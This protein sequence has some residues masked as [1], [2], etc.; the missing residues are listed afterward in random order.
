MEEEDGYKRNERIALVV[1]LVMAS[2]AV[3]T[4][5]VTFIY[6][7]YITNKVSRR[8]NNRK[9]ESEHERKSSTFCHIQVATE[10]G[11]QEFTF[12]Q[13]HSATGSFGKSNVIGHGAFGL[14]YRGVLQDGRK[15]AVKLMDQAGK[16]GEEEFQVEVELL[17]RLH[18]PYLLSLTGYCSDS[19]H[20]LLVYEFMAN[21]G[22]HEHLY[23]ISGKWNLYWF[24]RYYI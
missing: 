17:S 15:V 3:A 7:C 12:K 20:K 9:K 4:L 10:Q 14:V 16:Q 21:G 19:N 2:V 22:L 6:Y 1:I 8:L 24:D 18:S 23:P 5:F 11:L 13:L